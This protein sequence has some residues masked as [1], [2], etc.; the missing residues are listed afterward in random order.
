M[1]ITCPCCNRIQ[2]LTEPTNPTLHLSRDFI[3][4]S[5]ETLDD[6]SGLDSPHNGYIEEELG[7]QSE[8]SE[9]ETTGPVI[10]EQTRT[11]YCSCGA[12]FKLRFNISLESLK[13]P[14]V[15]TKNWLTYENKEAIGIRE[16]IVHNYQYSGSTGYHGAS[17]PGCSHNYVF[18]RNDYNGTVVRCSKCGHEK[19]M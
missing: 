15:N 13:L 1:Q 12:Q 10:N 4:E 17:V 14:V 18:K 9:D 2:H 6:L 5:L 3:N 11:V 7:F 16:E 19:T 8:Y